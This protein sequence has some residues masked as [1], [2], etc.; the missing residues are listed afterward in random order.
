VECISLSF[1]SEH[2]YRALEVLAQTS[3]PVRHLTILTVDASAPNELFPQLATHLPHLE[4]LHIIALVREYTL[5]RILLSSL[6]IIP[7]DTPV[8]RGEG[9]ARYW[10]P[11][12]CL[13]RSPA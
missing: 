4:A 10:L 11:H 8:L 12:R 9:R 13:I 5:L 2:G 6:S 3:T 1:F 7:M